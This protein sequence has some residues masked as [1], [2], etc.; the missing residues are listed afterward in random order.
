MFRNL[1]RCLSAKP[2]GN[3][4]MSLTV[5]GETHTGRVRDHN[6]DQYLAL[7]RDQSPPGAG[8]LLV[9][10]DGMGGQAAGEVASLMAVQHIE[11]RF[12]SGGLTS[13]DD[14][15]LEEALR[16]LL[17]DVNRAVL[18]AGQ[19]SDKRGMGTTCTLVIIEDRQ[20]Y[21]SHVGEP[22]LPAQGRR[23]ES[24][25]NGPQLGGGSGGNGHYD[26]GRSPRSP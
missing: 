4:N 24:D 22:G 19:D 5:K 6:E 9:V 16:E 8:A 12:R 20:L 17:G 15:D 23:T 26:P 21:Y 7:G 25:H 13:V 3:K 18:T 14:K 2:A 11:E 10:A 1:M